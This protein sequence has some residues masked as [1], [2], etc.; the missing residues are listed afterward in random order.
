MSWSAFS[1]SCQYLMLLFAFSISYQYL[2]LLS[3]FSISCQFHKF[4]FTSAT[5]ARCFVL[6]FMYQFGARSPKKRK[7]FVN[8]L[9]SLA[10]SIQ[11]DQGIILFTGDIHLFISSIEQF[12]SVLRGPRNCCSKQV[13][14]FAGHPVCKILYL[15]NM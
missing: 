3:A 4:N 8:I 10:I 12:L 5:P 14:F 1:I 2:M 15:V 9:I 11:Y 13:Y 6:V 7:Y